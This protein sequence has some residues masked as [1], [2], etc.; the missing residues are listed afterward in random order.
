VS[1]TKP[2]YHHGNLKA[3]LLGAAQEILETQ[4]QDALSM[5]SLAEKVG[6]SRTAL[7]H[8]FSNKNDL[9]CALAENGFSHLYELI[10]ENKN[11]DTPA[12]EQVQAAII[13]YLEFSTQHAAQYQLM[14]GKTLWHTE[15][16]THFQ[17]Y[18]KDCFRLYVSLFETLQ[19]NQTLPMDEPPLR[20]AQIMWASLH[21]LSQLM[22]DDI[23]TTKEE[24][25]TLA[26]HLLKRFL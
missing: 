25:N 18:A 23:L 21:G 10:S 7:Y 20:L 11:H 9:L 13:G 2:P 19:D 26:E 1:H 16:E 8:H 17:R 15:H 4:S 5:R 24:L 12:E 14:F 6:V 22:N 3:S